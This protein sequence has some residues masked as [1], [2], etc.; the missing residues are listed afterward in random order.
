MILKR[1]NMNTVDKL[2]TFLKNKEVD[3]RIL[4]FNSKT[5]TVKEAERALGINR[6]KIVKTILFVDE[7]INPILAIVTG[8]RR[9]DEKKLA[10][11]CGLKS[12]RKAA[13]EEVKMFTGYDV[14]ALPP[15]GHNILTVIDEDVLKN[16]VV[17]GGG[18]DVNSLLE[19]KT[20]DL[21]RLTNAIIAKI[22]R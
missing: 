13:P 17:Y 7:K 21:K 10:R 5:T 12:V 11:V 20:R 1:E 8:N 9:V 4:R 6:A 18:G 16:D 2:R 15:V 22:A 3:F 19:I 14:G